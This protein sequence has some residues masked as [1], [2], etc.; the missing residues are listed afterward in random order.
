[1][2]F[3]PLDNSREK[4]LKRTNNDLSGAH[5]RK[6]LNSF[7]SYVYNTIPLTSAIARSK[8]RVT[9]AKSDQNNI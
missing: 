8:S 9:N 7:K 1:M 5:Y 2:I 6:T 3:I 4:E